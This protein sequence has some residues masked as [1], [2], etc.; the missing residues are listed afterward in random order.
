MRKLTMAA[1]AGVMVAGGAL[2]SCASDPYYDGYS[3]SSMG[4]YDPYYDR[5]YYGPVYRPGYAYDPGAGLAASVLGSLL[6]TGYADVPHDRYGP[7]PHGMI[8]PDG[9]RIRCSLR[10]SYDRMYNAYVTRRVCR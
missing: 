7:N 2:A 8:A 4:R 3:V 9:H 6:G 1:L 5:S 10:R